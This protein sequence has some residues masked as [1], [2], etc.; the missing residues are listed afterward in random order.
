ML[1]I[2][3]LFIGLMGFSSC[4]VTQPFVQRISSTPVEVNLERLEKHVRYF[5]ETVHPRNYEQKDNLNAAADY[6]SAE[7]KQAGG[8]VT[9]QTFEVDG[10]TYRILSRILEQKTGL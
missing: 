10:K 1:Y 7:F 2:T 3:A 5:S 4:M 6:I 8:E 9:E